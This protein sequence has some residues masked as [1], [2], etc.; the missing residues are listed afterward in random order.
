MQIVLVTETYP[1]EVNGVAMTLERLVRGLVDRGH[2]VTVVRPR[3]AAPETPEAATRASSE[4]IVTVR[5]MPIPCYPEMRFG[6]PAGGTLRRLWRTQRPDLVHVATEG[7]LG[8]SAARAARRM[9][10]PLASSFHT[11]FHAYADHYGY[12]MLHGLALGWLKKVHRQAACTFVPSDTVRSRLEAEGFRNLEVLGRGV[13]TGLFAPSRRSEELR[14]TWGVTNGEPVALYVGRLATEKNL[15]LTIQAY[16]R[17]RGL[18]PDLRLVLV[19]EGPLR[20]RLERELPGAHFAGLRRGADLA[21]HYASAEYFLFASETETFGNV[22]TEA[23]ASGLVVLAY[24][25]AAARLHIESGSN[26]VTVPLG[27]EAAYLQAARSLVLR[28]AFWTRVRAHARATAEALSWDGIVDA[29]ER[30]VETL[31]A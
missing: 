17:M 15:T 6:F 7:P 22:V 8:R 23:M 9:G 28:P 19:G 27:N 21:A 31:L 11:N 1:P 24:D 5:G 3:P 13:D 2:D 10:I 30:K 18:R 12:G 20:G 16:E 25:Y 4:R 29:Y 26:G 14:T